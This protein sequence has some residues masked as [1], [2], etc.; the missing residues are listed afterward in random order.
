MNTDDRDVRD[1][2]RD[3]ADDAAHSGAVDKA[4]GHTKQTVGKIKEKVGSFIGDRELETKGQI[5]RAEGKKDQLKGEIKEKIEDVK[6]RVRAGVE[7]AKEKFDE[8][9]NR[10]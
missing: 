7:I 1:R 6:E 8:A 5:Q 9:R 10:K 4:K 2:A 3:A